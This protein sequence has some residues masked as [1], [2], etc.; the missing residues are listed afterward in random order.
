MLIVESRVRGVVEE[1]LV[2]EI[3]RVRGGV[4]ERGSRNGGSVRGKVLIKM[5]QVLEH[6]VA[7]DCV[8]CE[9]TKGIEIFDSIS[10]LPLET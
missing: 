7:R 2:L 5:V 4:G 6:V 8:T 3:M 9:A 10:A 1:I